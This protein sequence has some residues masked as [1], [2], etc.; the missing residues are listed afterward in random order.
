MNVACGH[1]VIMVLTE[2]GNIYTFG[3][4]QS[5]ALGLGPNVTVQLQP[6]MVSAPQSPLAKFEFIHAGP[7]HSV[8]IS[9]DHKCFTW[10][11]GGDGRLGLGDCQIQ[12]YP[13][14]VSQ[15]SECDL[16]SASCG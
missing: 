4:S 16:V 15:L 3:V 11:Y 9:S 13:Q 1:S 7:S 12:F 8:A 6:S 2:A 14:I 5:G 10:G